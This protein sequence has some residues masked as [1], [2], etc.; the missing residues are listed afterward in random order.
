[1]TRLKKQKR[2]ANKIVLDKTPRK[3]ER[4]ADP[5]SYESRKQRAQKQKKKHV[6]VDQKRIN[7]KPTKSAIE[8]DTEAGRRGERKGGRLADKIRQYNADKESAEKADNSR[9]Q[10]SDSE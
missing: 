10:T 7:A 6:S 9:E 8:R 4:L 3:Q 1:M 5:D 2:M